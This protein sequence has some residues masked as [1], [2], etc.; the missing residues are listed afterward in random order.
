MHSFFFG[1]SIHL[2]L[3]FFQSPILSNLYIFLF[4]KLWTYWSGLYFFQIDNYL[5]YLWWCCFF[6]SRIG[7]VVFSTNSAA[8]MDNAFLI[9]GFVITLTIA[10]MEKMSF[11]AIIMRAEVRYE[12]LNFGLSSSRVCQLHNVHRAKSQT[13]KQGCQLL[14]QD[15]S[16][17]VL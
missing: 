15:I 9:L 17:I 6:F 10:L 14:N 7:Q 3:G 5:L 11:H 13:E 2:L 12:S 8:L 16:Q 1:H 4:P